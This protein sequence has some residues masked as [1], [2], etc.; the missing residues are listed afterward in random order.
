MHRSVLW[1]LSAL[2]AG[3]E[4]SLPAT[5]SDGGQQADGQVATEVCGNGLDDDGDGQVDEGCSCSK[6]DTQ[7]CYGG[8]ASVAG[9]G[10]CVM[11][12]QTCSG[13]GEFASW[14]P[15]T[16][17]APPQTEVPGNGK[18]DDCDGT[19]D[20]TGLQCGSLSRLSSATGGGPAQGETFVADLSADGGQVVLITSAV[21]LVPNGLAAGE[22]GLL[23]HDRKS[24]KSVHVAN[25]GAPWSDNWWGVGAGISGNGQHLA[26]YQVDGSS[27][28][29]KLVAHDLKASKSTPVVTGGA[30]NHWWWGGLD[31]STDGRYLLYTQLDSQ[32]TWQLRLHDQTKGESST[33]ASGQG[34]W[35]EWAWG[36]GL[37]GDG[38]YVAYDELDATQTK[39]LVRLHDRTS[40]KTRTLATADPGAPDGWWGHHGTTIS[41]DGRFVAYSEPS[42]T[43]DPNQ[44]TWKIVL[45]DTTNDQK[46][47]AVSGVSSTWG[48]WFRGSDISLSGDGRYLLFHE[49]GD[50]QTTLKVYDRQSNSTALV[51]KVPLG[52]SSTVC[53]QGWCGYRHAVLSANGRCIAFSSSAKVLSDDQ[54]GLHTQA[55]MAP[56]PL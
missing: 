20:G 38:R 27:P 7:A 16:G 25:P 14:G 51:A 35:N 26:F 36:A 19:V 2:V 9:Q 52:P 24:G 49:P 40:G 41:A 11:G 45:H 30:Y 3:C 37:S 18:D 43:G 23:V 10:I 48:N 17:W 33:V 53:S 54:E 34:Y 15:C 47:T 29:W 56:N 39:R 50:V 46:L 1:L 28:S 22:W 8:L 31:L 4:G 21:E 5:A 44:W 32:S 6:G 55:Y 12:Q 13:T 42:T